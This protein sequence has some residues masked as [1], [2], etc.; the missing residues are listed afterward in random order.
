M[1]AHTQRSFIAAPK[2]IYSL[3]EVTEI[4]SSA[5]ETRLNI[6]FGEK[7]YR[8]REVMKV[9]CTDEN[10]LLNVETI[11]LYEGL[12]KIIRAEFNV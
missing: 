12:K 7:E 10:I 11:G 2:E 1:P 8:K 5:F 9:S 4:F 3:K 6:V